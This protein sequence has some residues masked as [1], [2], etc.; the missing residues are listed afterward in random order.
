MNRHQTQRTF[1]SRGF[2]SMK[3]GLLC[4]TVLAAGAAAAHAQ[5]CQPEWVGTFSGQPLDSIVTSFATWDDGGGEALYVG[6]L[7]Q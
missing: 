2:V 1:S 5:P 3:V 7:F 6:G 4:A